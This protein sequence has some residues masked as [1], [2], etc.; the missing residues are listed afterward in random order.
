MDRGGQVLAIACTYFRGTRYEDVA[1]FT[2]PDHRRHRLALACV[3]ALVPDITARGHTPSW[4]C[5]VLNR[6]S[7]LLA[8]TAGFRLVREYVHYAVGSPAR[9]SHIAA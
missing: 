6:A 5:S 9:R 8:W 7:R 3:T 4:N 1:V 2:T